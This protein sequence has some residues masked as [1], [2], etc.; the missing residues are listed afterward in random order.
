LLHHAETSIEEVRRLKRNR[1]IS[2]VLFVLGL[3]LVVLGTVLA[4][5]SQTSLT[6][7]G[8]RTRYPYMW[9]G[10]VIIILGLVSLSI[11]YGL[12]ILAQRFPQS[13]GY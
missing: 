10:M 9:R 8:L 6:L 4:D 13:Y 11:A 2:I 5:Y 1:V 7:D 12:M 3:G